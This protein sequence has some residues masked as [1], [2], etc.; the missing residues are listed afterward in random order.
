MSAGP[1]VRADC[2]ELR[3][4]ARQKGLK[5]ATMYSKGCRSLAACPIVYSRPRD[6]IQL[7]GIGP[8]TVS[9]LEK[10]LK[11]HCEQTGES[12]PTSPPRPSAVHP[13]E[14]GEDDFREDEPPPARK[15]RATAPK[16][17]IPQKGSGAYGILIALLLQIEDPEDTIQVFLTKLEIIRI[18]QPFCDSSYEHAER[19]GYQTAWNGIKTLISKGYVFVSGSPHKYCLTEEG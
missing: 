2:S 1:L 8:K 16:V 19:G 7:Q 10:R 14:S 17:Y 13:S 12:Y 3:D 5:T 6:L 18:A 4:D 9:I 15:K 11:A